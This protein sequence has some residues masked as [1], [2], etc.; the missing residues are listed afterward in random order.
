MFHFIIELV[1]IDADMAKN[2]PKACK[3]YFYEDWL[4]NRVLCGSLY[5]LAIA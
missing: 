4:I 2:M 1:V 5:I 3:T